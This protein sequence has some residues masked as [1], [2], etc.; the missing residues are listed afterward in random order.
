[1]KRTKND[2]MTLQSLPLEV[3]V[4]KTINR[5]DEFVQHF[6]TDGVYISCG[7]VKTVQY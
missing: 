4:Q 3:K 6:G 7:G 5:V 2:L 1:M